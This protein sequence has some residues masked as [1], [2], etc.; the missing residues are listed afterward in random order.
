MIFPGGT[1]SV[2]RALIKLASGATE[3]KVP[4]NNHGRVVDLPPE[5]V[6]ALRIHRDRR[7]ETSGNGNFVF[8]H[9]DGSAL[10]PDPVTQAFDRMAKRCGLPGLRLHDLRHTHASLML[11]QGIY[12]TI[13]SERLEHSSIGITIDLYSH[14]LLT[15]Q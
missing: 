9:S 5:S 14:A 10:N 6:E 8:C 2:R 7:P 4:K 1:L 15:V 12:P 3:L 11:S 13:V